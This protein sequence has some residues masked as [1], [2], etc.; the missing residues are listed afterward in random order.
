VPTPHAPL[1]GSDR[2]ARLRRLATAALATGGLLAAGPL[3]G[4][5]AAVP[6]PSDAKEVSSFT[7]GV[8]PDTQFYSRYAAP[9]VPNQFAKFGS[10]PFE[11]QT[12]WLAKNAKE[13]DIPFVAH[14]GDVVDQVNKPEEWVV[15]DN[16]MKTLEGSGIPYSILAG[17]HDVLDSSTSKFDTDYVTADEPYAKTFP[18]TRLAEKNPATFRGI[19]S[20]GFNTW[21]TFTAEGRQFLVLAL[22]WNASDATLA[23]ADKVIKDHPTMPVILTTH[24]LISIK[25]DGET[26]QETD[27]GLRLWDKLI[28][29]NDQIFLT[30]NGHYHGASRITKK[31][32]FG[33]DVHEVVI[34]YQMA[35]QGGNGYLGLYEFDFTNKRIN[36]EGLSPWVVTKPKE[37][38][39]AFDQAVL[40]GK[41]QQYDI[42]FDFDERFKGFNPSFSS[43]APQPSGTSRTERA[44]QIVLDGYT[45]P[46]TVAPS[47]PQSREDY[48]KV[49]GTVA[50]WRPGDAEPRADGVLREGG[51]VPDVA[52]DNDLHRVSIK[53]SGSPTA[54]VGDVTIKRDDLPGLSSDDAA[55]CFA[56]SGG[57][58]FSYLAT[59]AD[60]AANDVALKDGYTIETFAKMDASW[61]AA[62]NQ[63]SKILTR[64]GNRATIPGTPV[65]RWSYYVSP[66][67]LGISNLREF[68]FSVL[69][70][71]A[72]KDDRVAWSGEIMVDRWSHV[73]MVNDGGSITMYVDGAPVL[74]NASDA[75]GMSF[76]QGMSW[77]LGA[78]WNS[79]SAGNSKAGAGWNGCIGETRIVDHALPSS[80]WLTARVAAPPTPETPGTPNPGTPTPAPAPAPAPAP[81]KLVSV[82][83]SGPR[84]SGTATVGRTLRAE[85]GS[86]SISTGVAFQYQWLRDGQPIAGATGTAY[87][88]GTADAGRRIAVRVS[89]AAAGQTATA[90][91]RTAVRVAR[92][93][94]TVSV[95]ARVAGRD[96]LA[97]TF[98]VTAAG[99]S[100]PDGRIAVAVDGRTVRR[101]LAVK[102]GV[103]RLTV[104]GVRAGKH[105]VAVRFAGTDA[106]AARSGSVTLRV[107]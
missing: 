57:D 27:Y 70:G 95:K 53:G 41:H 103:A 31:N 91:S 98:R 13:L 64:S 7:F 37:H 15:A 71:D 59:G 20:T 106:I 17:N 3:V 9:S 97:L 89:A 79:D 83:G 54:K 62:A 51:A 2:A 43:A 77:L 47:K 102:D 25:A 65:S 73:A 11:S 78:D 68:Q 14:L 84:V 32:D 104:S 96:R 38:L 81:T 86:W 50:H 34:D 23:W 12:S 75:K 67:V 60:A 44:K 18:G 45:E 22:S 90:A 76:N 46:S 56:N 26:P 49:D 42:P 107:R 63:W 82:E 29:G 1:P 21:H 4:T 69:P 52:G 10:N 8:L 24:Q 35:Y 105:R 33:H 80:Q 66:A 61:T 40:K 74:R 6:A 36:A 5:A 99:I 92:L 88:L 19:D 30:F 55:V 101:A 39:T 87:R 48:P 72:K 94:P 28:K 85:A 16:A 58:R 100:R 93:R